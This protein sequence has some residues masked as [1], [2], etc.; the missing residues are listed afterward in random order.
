MGSRSNDLTPVGSVSAT[1]EIVGAILLDPSVTSPAV[2]EDALGGE[3]RLIP[4]VG[5]GGTA[6]VPALVSGVTAA[7]GRPEAAP[8]D[9]SAERDQ[10]TIPTITAHAPAVIPSH[11][12]S[13]AS[14]S[15]RPPT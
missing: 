3:M 4:N 7:V 12:M 14:I 2:V 8:S 13:P 9:S 6:A 1:I 15:R 5:D 10:P 11:K